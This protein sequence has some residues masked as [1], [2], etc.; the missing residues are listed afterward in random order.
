MVAEGTRKASPMSNDT[1]LEV[2]LAVS[3][4]HIVLPGLQGAQ[5][6]AEEN[7]TGQAAKPSVRQ[8]YDTRQND[9]KEA[10]LQLL[11]Q[12]SS[13]LRA[14]STPIEATS[15][16]AHTLPF[17]LFHM[18]I[19]LHE[20]VRVCV[21]RILRWRNPF[22]NQRKYSTVAEVNGAERLYVSDELAFSLKFQ[23][24]DTPAER[25]PLIPRVNQVV[26]LRDSAGTPISYS[27]DG[28]ES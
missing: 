18:T 25:V 17:R 13:R 26:I 3:V 6:L 14:D 15:R 2:R 8:A 21:L 11:T 24:A 20:G 22:S 10:Q 4:P 1:P 27:I 7:D 28:A 19:L 16:M 12:E 5:G 9:E 23:Q